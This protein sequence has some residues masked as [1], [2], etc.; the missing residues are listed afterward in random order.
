MTLR[1]FIRESVCSGITEAIS[2]RGNTVKMFPVS[3]SATD[4]IEWLEINGFHRVDNNGTIISLNHEIILLTNGKD[5]KI[6]HVGKFD[7]NRPGT[8]WIQFGNRNVIFT[9]QIEKETRKVPSW[10]SQFSK[11]ELGSSGRNKKTYYDTVEEFSKAVKE[12]FG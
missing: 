12:E 7:S 11:I 1:E 3:M 8:C 4:I 9:I 10:W 2:S 6:Y 5:D